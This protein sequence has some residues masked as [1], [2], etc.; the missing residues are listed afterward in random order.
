MNIQPELGNLVENSQFPPSPISTASV[1]RHF[2]GRENMCPRPTGAALA[3]AKE[4]RPVSNEDAERLR[5]ERK[6]KRRAYY[7]ANRERELAR[8]QAYRTENLEKI[9]TTQ[10]AYREANREKL[11]AD[12]QAYYA[13][14][15]EKRRAQMVAYRAARRAARKQPR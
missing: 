2:G 8:V 7:L 15:R 14:N 3:R 13:A 9:R 1:K 10:A 4:R 6:A 5:A 12:Q 11:K